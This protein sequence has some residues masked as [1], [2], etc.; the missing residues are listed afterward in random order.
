MHRILVA[1]AIALVAQA[2][3]A[4]PPALPKF[5]A[6]AQAAK[7][8]TAKGAFGRLFPRAGYGHVDTTA[9]DDWA[10]F[11]K[12]TLAEGEITAIASFRGTGDSREADEAAA[13]EFLQALDKAVQAKHHFAHREAHRSGAAF[14]GGKE[15]GN[16]L[17]FEVRQ[18]DDHI[19]ATCIEPGD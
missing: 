15:P 12:L 8:C 2:A 18:E 7:I 6:V 10:P 5:E 9:G 13:K 11:A 3:A 4:K 16:G 19:I 1:G 17:T 14:R